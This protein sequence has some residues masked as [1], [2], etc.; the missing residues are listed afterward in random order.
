MIVITLQHLK[1][2]KKTL[3]NGTLFPKVANETIKI[4][5]SYKKDSFYN[6]DDETKDFLDHLIEKYSLIYCTP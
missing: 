6:M 2:H 5:R 4:L 1:A 3:E